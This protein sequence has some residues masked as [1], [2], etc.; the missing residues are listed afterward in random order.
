MRLCLMLSYQVTPCCG[1]CL[2]FHSL[3]TENSVSLHLSLRLPDS[4]T[5]G[6]VHSRT[7][8]FLRDS[9][10]KLFV[11]NDMEYQVLYTNGRDVSACEYVTARSHMEAWSKGTARAQGRERVLNVYPMTNTFKEF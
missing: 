9:T 2:T 8:P 10:L 4:L 11:N 3:I 1:T 6:C 7:S 5:Q